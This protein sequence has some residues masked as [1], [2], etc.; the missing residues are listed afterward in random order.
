MST[1]VASSNPKSKPNAISLQIGA[2]VFT[3]AINWDDPDD[4]CRAIDKVMNLAQAGLRAENARL[5]GELAEL[6]NS[7]V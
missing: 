5:L 4:V 1:Q 6:R 7:R 3:C 2:A